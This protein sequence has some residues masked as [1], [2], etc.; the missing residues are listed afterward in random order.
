[1]AKA[2][3]PQE[4]YAIQK[5]NE[6]RILQICPD[7][8]RA[9]GIYLFYRI[10]ENNEPCV[11][12]GQ[13]LNLLERCGAHL[14]GRKTHIDKS[15]MKHKLYKKDNPNGWKVMVL[16]TCHPQLLDQEEQKWIEYY[17]NREGV[18]IYNVTGGG[19]FDKKEDIG[20]RFEVKLKTYKHGKD[21]A[22]EKVREKVK[23]YF[24]KYL[25]FVIKPPTGKV[26]ERKFQEFADFLNG[27]DKKD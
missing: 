19:Q 7:M 23:T 2:K 25:D 8:P 16:K 22:Y 4:R 9:S 21:F 12:I 24:D 14:S 27:N 26:K 5:S 3:T 13:S 11:Y 17:K 1:M 20:E 18:V 10:N 6:R 15:L